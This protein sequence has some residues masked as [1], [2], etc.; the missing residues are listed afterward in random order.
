MERLSIAS[1]GSRRLEIADAKG[2]YFE[3]SLCP[4]PPGLALRAYDIERLD[5][6]SV[7]RLSQETWGWECTCPAHKFRKIRTSP[8]KHLKTFLGLS[9]LQRNLLDTLIPEVSPP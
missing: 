5:T 6:E 1:D 9:P 7:Y 2:E 4:A 3:Y 8:C